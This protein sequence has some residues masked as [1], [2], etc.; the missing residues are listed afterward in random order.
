MYSSFRS[1]LIAAYIIGAGLLF[2]H[3]LTVKAFAE[4]MLGVNELK[5]T[6]MVTDTGTECPVIGCTVTVERQK[7]TFRHDDKYKCPV[8]DLY[9][10]PSSFEYGDMRNNLL[11]TAPEDMALLKKI[12][13]VKRES[14]MERNSSEDAV[15]WN[16]F[17]YLEKNNMLSGLLSYISGAA[18]VGPEII[19]WSY[20]QSE[21]GGWTGL[22]R[23]RME[24]GEQIKRGSEPDIIVKTKN[25]LFIIEVKVSARN[26][27]KPTP[28]GQDKGYLA[29]GEGWYKNVF[30]SDYNT[31]A[32]K[33]KKYEL[34]RY[35]LL[36]S[37]LAKEQNCDFY[38]ISLV[39]EGREP[40]LVPAFKKHIAE[41]ENRKYKRLDW[42]ELYGYIVKNAPAGEDK[43]A[44][45]KYFKNKTANYD[46]KRKLQ[47]AFKIE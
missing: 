40:G 24:F 42:E 17:R 5:D 31:V 21:G 25:A 3:G 14:R 46:S 1:K 39:L 15:S 16:A 12:F 29:G 9:I 18:Q 34:M 36:G 19:Y 32:V 7:G 10:S 33:D 44:L 22:N 28:R 38:L 4:G 41:T 43:D 35:W 2:M 45:I 8:H 13:K 27:T 11:W 20:S 47:K 23:A 30:T 6:I 26:E 37:W